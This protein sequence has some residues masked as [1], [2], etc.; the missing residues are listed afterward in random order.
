MV[1][2]DCIGRIVRLQSSFR[3]GQDGASRLEIVRDVGVDSDAADWAAGDSVA[4]SV[5]GSR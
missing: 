1:R 3:S 4:D 5:A 2:I